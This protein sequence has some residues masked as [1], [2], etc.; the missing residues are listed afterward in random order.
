AEWCWC[1]SSHRAQAAPLRREELSYGRGASRGCLRIEDGVD[2]LEHNASDIGALP[3]PDRPP[4][5]APQNDSVG[6]AE[7]E[8]LAEHGEDAQACLAALGLPERSR[9][10]ARGGIE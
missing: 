10:E 3:R 5:H 6:N 1:R 4:F 2:L 7:D 8:D 9:N